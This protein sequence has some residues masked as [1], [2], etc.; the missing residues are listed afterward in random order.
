M[1]C[2]GEDPL[3]P[4]EGGHNQDCLFRLRGMMKERRDSGVERFRTGGIQ[5][6][7]DSE[8]EG[9][10]KGVIQERRVQYRRDL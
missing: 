8:L 10:R 1:D 4:G 2:G 5:D 6:W 3:R 7:K 9:Y